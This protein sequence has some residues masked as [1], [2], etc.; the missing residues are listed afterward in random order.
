MKKFAISQPYDALTSGRLVDIVALVRGV[1]GAVIIG[2]D[3]SCSLEI[4]MPESSVPS[5]QK[6]FAG[7]CDWEPLRELYFLDH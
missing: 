2:G 3:P 5:A 7:K 6:V 4:Q 1:D